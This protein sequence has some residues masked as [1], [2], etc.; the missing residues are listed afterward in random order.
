M[1]IAICDDEEI[2]RID[3]KQK[4]DQYAKTYQKLVLCNEFESG[5]ELL[6]SKLV[7]DIIFLDYQMDGISGMETAEK[8]RHNKNNATI[9]FLS[10]YSEV[11]FQS[12]KVNTFRF[13][14]KPLEINELFAALNDFND[15]LNNEKRFLIKQNGTTYWVPFN[16]IIYLEAQNQH[17]IIRTMNNAYKFNETI[18]KAESLLPPGSFVRCH[19]SYI[20]N[21]EHIENHTKCDIQ[22]DNGERALISRYLYQNF[23]N[24]YI[25]YIKSKTAKGR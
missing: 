19:R 21:F 10:N 15:N 14:V 1:R 12:F 13:L 25:T 5:E 18:S 22:L 2:M 9:I 7:F 8:L 23:K 4:L 3:L 11:V 16:D 17:T 24:Q 20:V 6:S